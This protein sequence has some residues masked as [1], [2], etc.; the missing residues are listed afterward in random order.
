MLINKNVINR[1]ETKK[2]VKNPKKIEIIGLKLE[3]TILLTYRT[4]YVN[5]DPKNKMLVTNEIVFIY[6]PPYHK[7][8]V[9][10]F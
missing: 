10:T 2:K 3:L 6:K 4:I 8:S 5:I 7:C 9:F 1:S